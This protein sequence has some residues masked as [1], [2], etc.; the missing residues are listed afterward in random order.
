MKIGHRIIGGVIVAFGVG[1]ITGARGHLFFVLGG[2]VLGPIFISF[3]WLSLGF[4]PFFFGPL[5]VWSV[6]GGGGGGRFGAHKAL[7]RWTFPIWLYVSLSGI[8]VYFMLYH[9]Y[10]HS[11]T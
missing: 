9:L 1:V 5:F 11:M 8:V 4:L 10:P 6:L 3:L 7:A 2:R